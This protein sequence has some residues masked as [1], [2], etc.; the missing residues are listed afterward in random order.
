MYIR[1]AKLRYLLINAKFVDKI[2]MVFSGGEECPLGVNL[3]VMGL[4]A[5]RCFDV[6]VMDLA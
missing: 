6:R 4:L 5:W 3:D 2:S 1:A